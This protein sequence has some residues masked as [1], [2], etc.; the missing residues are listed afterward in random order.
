[1]GVY[2]S[3]VYVGLAQAHPDNAFTSVKGGATR[4]NDVRVEGLPQIHV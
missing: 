3:T 1:M 2:G 4:E